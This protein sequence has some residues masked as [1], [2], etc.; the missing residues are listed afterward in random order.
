MNFTSSFLDN[1]KIAL[2]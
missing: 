1:T 2:Q